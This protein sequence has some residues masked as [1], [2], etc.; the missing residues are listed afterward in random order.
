MYNYYLICNTY[1]LVWSTVHGVVRG[2]GNPLVSVFKSKPPPS[3]L[4][5][6]VRHKISKVMNTYGGPVQT[7]ALPAPHHDTQSLAN[8]R[9]PDVGVADFGALFNHS[10]NPN[11][12]VQKA[13]VD[14]CLVLVIYTL[15]ELKPFEEAVINYGYSSQAPSEHRNS[16]EDST[17]VQGG[18]DE[19]ELEGSCFS[20][21][22]AEAL[23]TLG[24][25]VKSAFDAMGLPIDSALY[26]PP[27]QVT[28]TIHSTGQ[29]ADPDRACT[30]VVDT[31]KFLSTDTQLKLA[32]N[33]L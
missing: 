21:A 16:D 32:I 27:V 9:M 3:D 30:L 22:D 20:E 1:I 14:G 7:S 12:E 13:I 8:V 2:A 6:N 18:H 33:G 19:M 11:C 25:S 31:S 5:P 10:D 15:S 26:G 29:D 28:K 24:R 4:D 17:V 23:F